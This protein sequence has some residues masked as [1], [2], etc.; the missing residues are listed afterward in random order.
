MH[1]LY[2]AAIAAGIYAFIYALTLRV[3]CRNLFNSTL[4]AIWGIEYNNKCGLFMFAACSSVVIAP[5]FPFLY[6]YAN[7]RIWCV[8]RRVRGLKMTKN[9]TRLNV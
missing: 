3:L 2:I 6:I 5:I 1:V 8:G 4:R 7:A 9:K